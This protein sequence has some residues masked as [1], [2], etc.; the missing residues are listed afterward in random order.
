MF[1][2]R[3]PQVVQTAVEE[4]LCTREHHDGRRRFQCACPSQDCFVVY[5][6][7]LIALNDQPWA[8]RYGEGREVEALYRWRDG[9]ELP[10][11]Q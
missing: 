8:L 7:I 2:D 5:Q 9:D 1:L 10:H 3:R 4:V 6:F 11:W